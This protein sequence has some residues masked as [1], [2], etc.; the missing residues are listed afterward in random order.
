MKNQIIKKT[1]YFFALIVLLMD[2]SCSFVQ[3][4]AENIS[5][6]KL[7]FDES[8]QTV[9]VCFIKLKSPDNLGLVFVTRR[10][11]KEDGLVVGAIRELFLGPTKSEELKGIMSE[12]PVG[13]RLINVEE[14][15]DEIFVDISPQ[16]LTGGGSATMQLRYIQIY[17]TL[18][19][20]APYKGV[21]L[22][23]DGKMLKAI[24]G[25]GLEVTQPLTQINDYT[26][27]YEKT[28]TVQP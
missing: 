18:K 22:K 13:T 16:Y 14:S 2:T 3:N 6:G 11:P 8:M 7:V 23:V 27:K 25:E 15:E 10:I 12:I 28:E 26:K 24:G 20:T 1:I 19:K 9:K 5:Q 21:Y 4:T 17:N